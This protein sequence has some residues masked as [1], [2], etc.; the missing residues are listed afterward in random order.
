MNDLTQET[1][2]FNL[3]L[4]SLGET[5]VGKTSIINMYSENIFF[6]NQLALISKQK[7]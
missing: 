6:G 5:G 3:K 1:P 4:L 7:I 2:D